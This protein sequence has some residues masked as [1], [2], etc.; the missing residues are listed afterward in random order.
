M[1]GESKLPLKRGG[2]WGCIKP[3]GPRGR[4][5]G[6]GGGENRPG[7]DQVGRGGEMQKVCVTIGGRE[8]P[9]KSDRIRTRDYLGEGL[10]TIKGEIPSLR[11][12][13]KG[14]TTGPDEGGTD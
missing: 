7:G 12:N 5:F 1:M 10:H 11:Q 9:T 4:D 14:C 13:G 8:S 6:Q 3:Q 2:G